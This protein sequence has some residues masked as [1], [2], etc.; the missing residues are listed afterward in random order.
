MVTTVIVTLDNEDTPEDLRLPVLYAVMRLCRASGTYPQCLALWGVRCDER[1][2]VTSG[3]F[4]EIWR[5]YFEDR[6]VALKVARLTQKAKI[7]HFTKNFSREAILWRSLTH[8]NLQPFYGIYRLGDPDNRVCLV[9]PW[10]ENG[11]INEYLEANP[12]APRFPL[13]F[14]ILAGLGYLHQ[15]KV[16]HGDLKCA[17][18]N[19]LMSPLGSACLA[20]FGLS[21]VVDTEIL[22]WTSLE[23][24]TQTGGTIRWEAPELMDELDDGSAPKPTLLSDVYS[25]ASVMY[26]VLTGQI[27]F[28]EF[29]REATVLSKIMKGITPTKPS[30]DSTLELTDEVWGVM[31]S[32]WS[33]D[34]NERLTVE[35]T[36]EV[37]QQLPRPSLTEERIAQNQTKLKHPKITPLTPQDFIA[38][39]RGHANVGFSEEE[40]KLLQEYTVGP[41][42]SLSF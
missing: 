41:Y 15:R 30:M 26:E 12:E 14:D 13:V 38:A 1:Q 9:S 5:G 36:S 3:R 10:A 24:M 21:S 18:A 34:P 42:W 16:V 20:D 4:G 39:V 29:P 8:P 25:M 31:Q 32:C 17:C 28:Y 19:I 23:T 22:R 11:N 7:D 40:V 27:P 37:L 33:L 6:P 2:P 35:Q